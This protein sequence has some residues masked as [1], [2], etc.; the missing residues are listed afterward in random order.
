MKLSAVPFTKV[1]IADRFWTPRQETNRKV[2]IPF[3]L[4]QLEKAG[5]MRNFDRAAEGKRDGYEGPVFMDSDAY[6]ALEAASYSLAQH[7]DPK[8]SARVDGLIARIAA[9]QMPDG[10]L[11]SWYQVN[12]PDRR[13]TNLRDNH[14]IYCAGHLF[15]AAAAHFLATGKRTLLQVATKFADHLDATFGDA[16]GKRLGYCGHPEA[17]LALVKLADVAGEKRYF[18]L[19]RHMAENRGARLFAREHN[20]PLDRYDGAYWQDDVPIREHRVIKGHAVR[21]AYLM[22]GVTDIVARTDD[23]GLR[24]MLGRVWRNTTEKNMYITGGIGPSAHNEGFTTDYD[25]PNLTAYQETCASIALALWNHRMA[26]LYGDARYAD[27][28]ERSLYNGVLAGVSLD[29]R[30]YFYV[31]PLE[32][33]G[34]HHRLEWYGCACCPPNVT[35]T[36]ASLGGYAYAVSREALWVNLYIAG[37]VSVEVAGVPVKLDVKTDYPWDGRVALTMGV[38]GRKPGGAAFELRLRV[39]GWCAAAHLS[40]N[41]RKSTR[42]DTDRGFLVLQRKWQTGDTV[43][44]ELDMPVERIESHP[45]VKPNLGQTALQ[46]GP[47]VYCVE[48]SDHEARVADIALPL[49]SPV[50]AEKKAKLLGGVVVL[51]A[52]GVAADPLAW[53]RQ[54]YRPTPEP[55]TIPLTAV[56]YYAWDNREAGPMRVWLPVTPPAAPAGGP[57]MSAKVSVSFRNSNSEPEGIHDGIEQLKSSNRALQLCHWWPHEGTEEWA[58]YT[59]KRPITLCASR[60]FWF[61]DT[62]SGACRLPAAWRIEYKDGDRW[63]PVKVKGDYPVKMDAWCSVEFEPVTASEFRLVVQLQKGWAAGVHEWQVTELDDDV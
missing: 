6:K 5:N 15:E 24:K 11:N 1:K 23:E 25:L 34:N 48:Q 21:A 36:L 7:P 54:L 46:R 12:A 45:G 9:A 57:E 38:Q 32:S 52:E 22:S 26:L 50:K 62:G 2:S 30:R 47:L 31:N 37:S 14:E 20:T 59:W 33:K 41:G 58:Q 27:L 55:Q 43:E 3:S 8:L 42:L 16:D 40:V 51:K 44:L 61:D 29:G 10:Y 39:P 4:D 13:F 53:N 35:R 28:V 49:G 63:A 18:L 60:V 17:E 56:P 19:A